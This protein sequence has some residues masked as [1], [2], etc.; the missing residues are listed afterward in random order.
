MARALAN[1][2]EGAGLVLC[3]TGALS[4]RGE[5]FG[6]LR[7][8]AYVATVTSSE[9]ELELAGLADVYERTQVGPHLTRYLTTGHYFY[10]LNGGNAV[11][12]LHGASVGPF[13]ST[14]E[15][16]TCPSQP[17]TS[18]RPSTRT[19]MPARRRRS[20]SPASRHCWTT[21][22]RTSPVAGSSGGT[23]RRERSWPIPP[24]E[25]STSNTCP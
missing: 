12:F 18:V 2:L 15:D 23:L 25:S 8:G 11:N 10:L 5:D 4:L 14:S 20:G 22:R 13:T 24:D 3:A 7:N 17:T 9:D 1:G 6:R 19:W 21:R 16:A